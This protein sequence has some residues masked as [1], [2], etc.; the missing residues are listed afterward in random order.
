MDKATRAFVTYVRGYKEHHCKFIFRLQEL[1]IGR[2][3]T[4]LGLLR[5]PRMPDLKRPLGAAE[6]SP[7]AVDPA[8]VPYR[9]KAREKQRQ[10][11][12]QQRKAEAEAR[13]GGAAAAAPKRKAAP[14][15]P[16]AADARL[17]A[18]KR[19]QLQAIDET[20]A[21]NREYSL[22]KKLKKGKITQHQYDKA[23]GLA[24][25]SE[26]EPDEEAGAGPTHGS[27]DSEPSSGGE[28]GASDGEDEGADGV[29]GGSGGRAGAGPGSRGGA[30]AGDAAGRGGGGGGGEPA[31]KGKGGHG[32]G[33]PGARRGGPLSALAQPRGALQSYIDKK[34]RKNKKKKIKLQQKQNKGAR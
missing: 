14:S 1:N 12:L 19:R 18:A 10:K 26:P 21:L 32:Q 20:D 5:L 33:G 13:G 34:A 9:D 7:S 22:L 16:E 30:G 2:L 25:D 6:F 15:A 28:G 23:L 3:A 8:S 17:P 31:A 24:S 11:V 29:G 4:G 27:P